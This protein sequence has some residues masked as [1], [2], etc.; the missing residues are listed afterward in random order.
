MVDEPAYKIAYRFRK[1]L[2]PI[3]PDERS[4]DAVE[5]AADFYR[6]Y[7]SHIVFLYVVE[8]DDKSKEVD[9]LVKRY[10]GDIAYELKIKRAGEGETAASVI[11]EEAKNF[12]DL[13][14]LESRGYTGAEALLHRS[15]SVAVALAA[16]TS[17]L[18]LR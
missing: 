12:Y 18:I 2:V 4:R 14:I 3:T 11:V 13:V 17:V 6:R 1:I 15:T 8:G 10:A 9:E 5:V 7:G 16:P